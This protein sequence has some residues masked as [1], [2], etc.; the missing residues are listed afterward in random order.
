MKKV[1]VAQERDGGG[2]GVGERGKGCTGKRLWGVGV[3][4]V[5]VAQERDGGVVVKRVQLEQERDGG[6][7]GWVPQERDGGGRYGL[8]RKEMVVEGGG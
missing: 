2:W 5:R 7:G 4:K 6:G 1:R 8:Q 3:K